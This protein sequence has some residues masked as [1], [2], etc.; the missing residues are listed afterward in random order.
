MSHLR[1]SSFINSWAQTAAQRVS[2]QGQVQPV[3]GMEHRGMPMVDLVN[4][5]SIFQTLTICHELSTSIFF[6]ASQAGSANN[7][8]IVHPVPK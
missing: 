8:E 5:R 2:T 1:P 4:D 6:R 7:A 3:S